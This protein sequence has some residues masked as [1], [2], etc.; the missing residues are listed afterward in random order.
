MVV[1]VMRCAHRLVNAGAAGLVMLMMH[2]RRHR[3]LETEWR[4]HREQH[5]QRDMRPICGKPHHGAVFTS[6]GVIVNSG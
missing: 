1:R 3:T 2:R 5:Q 4:K 6:S